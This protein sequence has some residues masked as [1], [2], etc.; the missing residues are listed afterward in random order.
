M[1]F[2][3]ENDDKILNIIKLLLFVLLL[4]KGELVVRRGC[5]AKG[6]GKTAD[7]QA[8]EEKRN[9]WQPFICDV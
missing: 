6:S 4:R 1:A 5:K 9:L 7:N 8:A 3:N 2:Y